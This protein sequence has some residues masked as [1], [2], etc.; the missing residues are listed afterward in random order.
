[1]EFTQFEASEENQQENQSL[2]FSD[3]Y[4]DD[5]VIDEVDFID[6]KEY[7]EHVSFCR[8]VYNIDEYNKFP[9][10]TIDPRSAVYEDDKM[11]F[12]KDDT[13]SELYAPENREMVDFDFF[14]GRKNLPVILKT[15]QNFDGEGGNS[16]FDSVIYGLMSRKIEGKEKPRRERAKEVPGEKIYEEL[17][18]IKEEIK[19]DRRAFGFFNKCFLVNQLIWL[20]FKIF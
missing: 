9:N 3:E 16:F 5:Q 6:E 1:M 17:V 2:N 18:E 13:Q 19:L 4:G 14:R 11:F 7:E 15:F 10:Q 8:N 20:F 12:R